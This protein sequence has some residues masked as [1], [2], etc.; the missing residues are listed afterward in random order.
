LRLQDNGLRVGLIISGRT[1]DGLQR[2]LTQ[3]KSNPDARGFL[4]PVGNPATIMLVPEL[5]ECEFPLHH[6]GKAE[7]KRFVKAKCQ[8]EVMP[9]LET[10]GKVRLLFTPQIEY[11]DPQKW[12][13]LNPKLALSVQGLRSTEN[14][15]ALRWELSLGL[16]DYVVIGSGFEKRQT[17]G[18]N[19]L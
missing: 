13:R 1:P 18:Y 6:D 16:N 17:L 19:F 9:T 4:R 7:P 12:S 8:I 10:D 11:D 3:K 14:F 15:E 2:L 5:E